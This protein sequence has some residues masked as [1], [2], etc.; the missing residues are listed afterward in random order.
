MQFPYLHIF[1]LET[2]LFKTKGLY[3]SGLVPTS[4]HNLWEMML[5]T[6]RKSIYM[7]SH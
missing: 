5:Y 1:F 2:Q 6:Q 3:L 4:I 7:T